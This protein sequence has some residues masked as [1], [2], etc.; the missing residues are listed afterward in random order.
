MG[1]VATETPKLSLESD[2]AVFA[3]L[4]QGIRT[5]KTLVKQTGECIK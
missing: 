1:R 4:L 5:E 3:R 2:D